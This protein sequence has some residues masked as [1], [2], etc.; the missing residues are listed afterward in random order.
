M[1]IAIAGMLLAVAAVCGYSQAISG[2]NSDKVTV[3]VYRV[4][5]FRAR[6][7]EPSLFCDDIQVAR[8]DNGR[9]FTLNLDPGK[10]V[11]KSNDE[12]TE[13]LIDGKAGDTHYVR[14]NLVSGA[15]KFWGGVTQASPETAQQQLRKLKPLG[16]KKVK[17]TSL[18]SIETLSF[19]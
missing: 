5:A 7:L 9:Y 13:V 2:A 19:Q 12:A 18:V 10:H 3:V 17:D 15:W 8:M 1:R 6:A 14:I 11:I 16:A 4:K